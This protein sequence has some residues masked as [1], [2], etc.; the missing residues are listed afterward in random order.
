MKKNVI[1]FN[2]EPVC[3]GDDVFNDIYDIELPD[4]ATLGDLMD[5]VRCGGHGND[6][7]VCFPYTLR[8]DSWSH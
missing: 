1:K 8:R 4:S 6:W 3:M 2:R 5:A 7:P